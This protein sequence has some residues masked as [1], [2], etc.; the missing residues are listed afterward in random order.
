MNSPDMEDFKIKEGALVSQA[1]QSKRRSCSS[2]RCEPKWKPLTPPSL[3]RSNLW[4]P[5]M[6]SLPII[7]RPQNRF[8]KIQT[9]RKERLQFCC[10]DGKLKWFVPFCHPWRQGEWNNR[11]DRL[12]F[13]A[14]S[15]P[16][17]N[18]SM[19]YRPRF[20]GQRARFYPL[21]Q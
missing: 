11:R 18:G 21:R 17:R 10:W 8:I 7:K 5:L 3:T 20:S 16:L 4:Q 6:T 13:R 2:W 15:V 12:H 19:T 9:N 14:D 1:R